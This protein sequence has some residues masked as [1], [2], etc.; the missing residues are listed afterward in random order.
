MTEEDRI[1]PGTGETAKEL[2]RIYGLDVRFVAA[3]ADPAAEKLAE[4]RDFASRYGVDVRFVNLPEES[5]AE[6][7]QG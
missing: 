1:V 4:R 7:E 6:N 3:A 2:A 5:E